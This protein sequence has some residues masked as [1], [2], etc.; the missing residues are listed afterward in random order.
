[1][2]GGKRVRFEI[3]DS[4]ARAASLQISYQLLQVARLV[5]SPED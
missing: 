2:D 5:V 1:M 4:R 3:N